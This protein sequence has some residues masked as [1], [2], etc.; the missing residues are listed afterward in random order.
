MSARCPTRHRSGYI[1]EAGTGEERKD[2]ILTALK[3]RN[4]A[5]LKMARSIAIAILNEN[6]NTPI[7]SDDVR[8]IYEENWGNSAPGYDGLREWGNWAGSL[9]KSPEF[10]PV[11]IDRARRP[12]SNSN[13]RW[14]W[15]LRA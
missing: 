14:R 11:I 10:E 1:P 8:P 6:G 12:S 4:P 13:H 15:R 7:I 5:E 2:A 9:F 3:I